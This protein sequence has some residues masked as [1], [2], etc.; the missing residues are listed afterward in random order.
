MAI[1]SVIIL[2][3]ITLLVKHHRRSQSTMTKFLNQMANNRN[4][5]KMPIEQRRLEIPGDIAAVEMEVQERPEM[6]VQ[7]RSELA[8]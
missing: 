3:L 2:V 6:E 7:G 8:A 5:S 1:L 4:S